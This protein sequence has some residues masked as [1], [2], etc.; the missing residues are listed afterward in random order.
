MKIGEAGAGAGY[1][2]FFLSKKVGK[3]GVI[4]AND[5]DKFV[6]AALDHYA[7]ESRQLKNIVTVLGND[8]D[9]DHAFI[10]EDSDF[11]LSF[12]GINENHLFFPLYVLISPDGIIRYG[13]KAR[14][15]FGV[16]DSFIG[17]AN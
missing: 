17:N 5:N 9:L 12:G 10:G 2:T 6:L 14:E 4:Y 15:G 13:G 11:W 8:T 7:E 16:M 1:F 3:S